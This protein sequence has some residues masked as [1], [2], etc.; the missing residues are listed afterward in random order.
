MIQRHGNEI[1]Y[2]LRIWKK[3]IKKDTRNETWIVEDWKDLKKRE[4]K[5]HIQDSRVGVIKD[6]FGT[7]WNKQTRKV[8]MI[9]I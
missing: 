2:I 9:P 1:L 6:D 7:T 3:E 8:H 4:K 5:V